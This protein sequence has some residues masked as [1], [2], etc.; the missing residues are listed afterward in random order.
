M[1]DPYSIIKRPLVTEKG[2]DQTSMGK[3][4]FEVDMNANKI[5][6][7]E[8][9]QKIFSVEVVKV[10]T[11]IV[12]GKSKRLGRMGM[13]KTPDWKKAYVTLAQGQSIPIFEGA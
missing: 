8:A 7:A 12:K 1:R 9:V 13:G 11:L 6:I 3:Y 4:I 2:M 5:E 10:N